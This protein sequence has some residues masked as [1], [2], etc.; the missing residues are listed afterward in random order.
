MLEQVMRKKEETAKLKDTV[1]LEFSE[2]IFTIK[3]NKDI[4]ASDSGF[5]VKNYI[6]I[7]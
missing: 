2:E 6:Q 7:Q 1:N 3:V 5:D 4:N